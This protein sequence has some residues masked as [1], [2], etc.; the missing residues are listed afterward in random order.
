MNQS[1]AWRVIR[2]RAAAAGIMAPIG[3][4]TFRATGST[5]YLAKGGALDTRRKWRRMGARARPSSM[6]EQRSGSPKTG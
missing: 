1:D 3:R 5:A 4:H 2:R 6:I